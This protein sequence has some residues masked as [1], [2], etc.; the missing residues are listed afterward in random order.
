LVI[1]VNI[2]FD[3][4]FRDEN[5]FIPVWKSKDEELIPNFYVGK[6]E[7]T[8][9]FNLYDRVFTN[10]I[11]FVI[12]SD[13]LLGAIHQP[14]EDLQ[15]FT[16]ND[17]FKYRFIDFSYDETERNAFLDKAPRWLSGQIADKP[18]QEKFLKNKVWVQILKK[19]YFNV[20]NTKNGLFYEVE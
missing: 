15:G 11:L 13:D 14:L 2:Y 7:E 20:S 18:N 4:V 3:S 10:K 12:S 6:I 5:I 8:L 19:I 16:D 9:I 17:S 1:G